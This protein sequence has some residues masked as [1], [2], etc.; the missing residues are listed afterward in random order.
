MQTIETKFGIFCILTI[1]SWTIAMDGTKIGGK[2]IIRWHYLQHYKSMM[3][4]SFLQEMTNN[5]RFTFS[6]SDT[7]QA[8]YN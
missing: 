5:D 4:K 1:M 7:T 2:I 3:P 8:V 6:V